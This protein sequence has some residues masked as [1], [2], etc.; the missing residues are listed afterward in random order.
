MFFD[1]E[2]TVLEKLSKVK[3]Q[4]TMSYA[5]KKIRTKAFPFP[6]QRDSKHL[7][8]VSN[9]GFSATQVQRERFFIPLFQYEI[10]S[11]I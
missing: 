4:Y 7:Q 6:V 3:N 10:I 1:L 11:N 9:L 5:V 8:K 2:T